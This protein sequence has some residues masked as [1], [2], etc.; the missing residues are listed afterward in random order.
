MDFWWVVKGPA[1]SITEQ[2][3]ASQ[4]ASHAEQLQPPVSDEMGDID[5]CLVNTAPEGL[6]PLQGGSGKWSL[7]ARRWRQILLWAGSFRSTD[8]RYLRN[9]DL[10]NKI[11]FIQFKAVLHTHEKFGPIPEA[12]G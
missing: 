10:G 3:Q 12:S 11:L 6:V 1:I 4:P 8:I 2:V 7:G 5:L 9:K